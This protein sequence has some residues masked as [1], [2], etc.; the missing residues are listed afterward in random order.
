M[1]SKKVLYLNACLLIYTFSEGQNFVSDG[2][3]TLTIINTNYFGNN[4]SV[5]GDVRNYDV[6]ESFNVSYLGYTNSASS[7]SSLGGVG[8]RVNDVGLTVISNSNQ[9]QVIGGVGGIVTSTSVG[10]TI[11]QANGGLGVQV[12]DEHDPFSNLYGGPG[13]QQVNIADGIILGGNAGTVI[14]LAGNTGNADGGAGVFAE[15]VTL[16]LGSASV[17]GGHGGTAQGSQGTLSANGGNALTTGFNVNLNDISNSFSLIGGD[18]GSVTSTVLGVSAT[19][20]GGVGFDFQGL[21]LDLINYP[22]PRDTSLTNYITHG[23]F[24]G[25]AGGVAVGQSSV[26]A[27]GGRGV[28]TTLQLMTVS[29]GTFRGGAG[30]S[31]TASSSVEGSAKGG[32]GFYSFQNHKLTILGGEFYGGNAGI[33]NGVN[34]ENGAGL[35]AIDTD[36]SIK[37]GSFYGRGIIFSSDTLNSIIEI[38]GG[39]FDSI[40][41]QASSSNL[42]SGVISG[43]NISNLILSGYSN[44]LTTT[45]GA[46]DKL[47]LSGEGENTLNLGA[48][49]T[50]SSIEST[51]GTSIVNSWDDS[52]FTDATINAG[53]I[54]FNNQDFSLDSGSSFNLLTPD[55]SAYF[56]GSQVNIRS[57]AIYDAGYGLTTAQVFNVESGASIRSVLSSDGDGGYDLPNINVSELIISSN[58]T[59]TVH[60]DGTYSNFSSILETDGLLLEVING[61]SNSI[62]ASDVVLSGQ[63]WDQYWMYGISELYTKTNNANGEP[64]EFYARYGIQDLSSA[65]EAT[66]DLSVL[67][68]SIQSNVLNNTSA[69]DLLV[70]FG[71]STAASDQMTKGFLRTT[72]MGSTLAELSRFFLIRSEFELG[73][74]YDRSGWL[75]R[76]GLLELEGLR[77]GG[78]GR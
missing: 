32:D 78:I 21:N 43:G 60:S 51:S 35:R 17:I 13:A 41:L 49:N 18:G 6:F 72:E 19:A 54:I 62:T 67:L 48:G 33:V 23:E 24:T 20:S 7:T 26:N 38:D 61:I 58:A 11:V 40:N 75:A 46:I 45:G 44:E 9:S 3:G 42:S 65:L 28:F 10:S 2:S 25:G 70:D 39:N 16:T 37:N 36:V 55:A 71:S 47:S 12:N 59:W 31:V 74:I 5:A 1:W 64:Y 69:R 29:N 77:R 66:G 68:N 56:N 57:N 4:N 27:D 53:S 34:D 63:G 52:H 14:G 50:L 73:S 8:L 15:N 76:R 22:Q 30:G